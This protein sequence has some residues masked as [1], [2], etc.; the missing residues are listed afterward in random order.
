LL[1][2]IVIDNLATMAPGYPGRLKYPK[3]FAL[4]SYH[5]IANTHQASTFTLAY[6]GHPVLND[7]RQ[8]D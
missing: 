1:D 5:A 6:P 7:S 2:V 3:Q 8:L 4:V